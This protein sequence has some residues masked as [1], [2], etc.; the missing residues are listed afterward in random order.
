[1]TTNVDILFREQ[2]A[3]NTVNERSRAPAVSSA[4]NDYAEDSSYVSR[5]D[6]TDR[7]SFTD[8]LN[9]ETNQTSGNTEKNDKT[10]STANEIGTDADNRVELPTD[11][12][13]VIKEAAVTQNKQQE[14]NDLPGDGHLITVVTEEKNVAVHVVS[15]TAGQTPSVDSA[16]EGQSVASN[17]NNLPSEN[18]TIVNSEKITSETA[19][20]NVQAPNLSG[21]T[22]QSN[23]AITPVNPSVPSATTGNN[24]KVTKEIDTKTPADGAVQIA[25]TPA[26]S[27]APTIVTNA[28]RDVSEAPVEQENNEVTKTITTSVQAGPQVEK[29]AT[30]TDKVA[31]VN[32]A[33]PELANDKTDNKAIVSADANVPQSEEAKPGPVT[34]VS[35]DKSLEINPVDMVLQPTGAAIESSRIISASPAQNLANSQ[36]SVTANKNS[37]NKNNANGIN[38]AKLQGGNSAATQQT[39]QNASAQ[40]SLLNSMK[41]DVPLDLGIGSQN[42][43]TALP[44]ALNGQ[45]SLSTGSALAAQDISGQKAISSIASTMK[46]ETPVTQR[47]VNEQITIAINKNII[48]GQNSFSIRLNPAE[49]GKVDI[50]LEFMADGKMQAVMTVESEKTLTMLQRDQGALEKALQDAG[51][52]LTDKNMNFSLMKQNQENNAQQF[53]GTSNSSNDDAALEDL[54]EVG[55]LQEIR[56]GYSTKTV[57]ISV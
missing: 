23:A 54:I 7:K 16:V 42:F 11:K 3:S 36:T 6:R 47:M 49:L 17:N 46:A 40:V 4:K 9:D 20:N 34:V 48:N 53:A 13:N 27:E 5:E 24:E 12:S 8:H 30:E 21:D 1:M 37:S 15:N 33:S 32:N 19:N 35:Q 51:I 45:T 28:Q 10:I 56:M 55:T 41:S 26:N 25:S 29:P 57:D 31:S 38:T 50:K 18:K 2:P 22:T 43:D 14:T 44:Q 39:A 52:N